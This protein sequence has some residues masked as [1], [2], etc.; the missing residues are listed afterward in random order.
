MI[1]SKLGPSVEAIE[2][3][4]SRL[5]MDCEGWRKVLRGVQEVIDMAREVIVGH[6]RQW[7][8]GWTM[9]QRRLRRTGQMVARSQR[10]A[11]M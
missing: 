5:Q 8:W 3:P 1:V 9:D 2:A 11:V 4:V 10:S 7:G 6:R